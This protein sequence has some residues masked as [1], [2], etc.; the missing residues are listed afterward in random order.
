[1]QQGQRMLRCARAVPAGWQAPRLLC[2]QIALGKVRTT[3]LESV[4]HAAGGAADAL[5]CEAAGTGR[6]WALGM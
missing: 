5:G 6:G 3:P 1:M 4:D 2:P